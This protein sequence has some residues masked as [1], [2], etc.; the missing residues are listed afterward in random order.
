MSGLGDLRRLEEILDASKMAERI[1]MLLPVGVRPRQLQVRS[2]LLGI[3]ATLAEQR[4]AHLR[5]IHETLIG[6][7]DRDR[8]RLGVITQWK[9]GPHQL[10]YRQTEY[11]FAR[12]VAALS[13]AKPDG[14]PSQTLSEVLAS[15]LE[16]SVTVLG[17]GRAP[18][19]SSLAIDWTDYESF[20]R[21]PRKPRE[22]TEAQ[23]SA[24]PA[25]ADTDAQ[26]QEQEQ[27]QHGEQEKT[28][29]ETQ[30][31]DKDEDGK[32]GCADTEAA[33]GHRKVNT[34]AKSETFYG[35][36]LQAAT[37]VKE[38][39]GPQTPELVRRIQIAS[40]DHDPPAMIT[41][42]I[43]RMV[44][45]G[46]EI[47]DLLA[48]SGYSYR[49]PATFAAPMRSAG[50]ILIMDIHPN[51]RGINGTFQGAVI[52]NGC[53]YCPATPKALFQLGPPAPAATQEELAVHD[54]KTTELSRYKLSPL[55]APDSDGYRRVICPAAKG[56]LRCP[57]RPTSIALSHERPTVLETPEH[58]PLCC[59]QQT[60]TVPP[61]VAA[62]TS[63]KHDYPSAAHRHSYARRTAS[64]RSFSKVCD[65]ASTDISRG[66]C[67]LM[68]L[69]PNAI[70]L[71]C[72]FITA[73]IRTADAFAARQA[74]NEQ[75][76]A[77]GLPPRRRRR[78]RE[79]LHDLTAQANA[80]PAIAA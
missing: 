43:E 55:S 68:G 29:E 1:E 71:I 13:K 76:A 59:T 18:Q 32:A 36:Y 44:K 34:P 6:L 24:Q 77:N 23:Q 72:A 20:A 47:A 49:Q 5:R 28:Q 17:G 63:Q 54:Q 35:Y 51:D 46:I 42:V 52:A 65:P 69:T 60:I 15:L 66:W 30:E 53:L 75:R 50:A 48:D 27:E 37:I 58:P 14:E 8:W 7:P 70:M 67:R 64:E 33:W 40:C 21:P 4:P 26:E 22:K 80:P 3:L 61:S 19:S 10:T 39:G 62:K 9:S 12:V 25:P 57:L 74:E 45:N 2:L 11:T 78:R 31:E 16:G 73:N 38:E 41:P 79:G 56:K